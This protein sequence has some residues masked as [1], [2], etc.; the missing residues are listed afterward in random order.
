MWPFPYSPISQ[1]ASKGKKFL[2]VEMS[3]G[4]MLQDVKL[5][6]DGKS[7]VLFYGRPGGSVITPEDILKKIKAI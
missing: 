6:V 4:Q 5:G 3:L 2:V 1:F 7:K